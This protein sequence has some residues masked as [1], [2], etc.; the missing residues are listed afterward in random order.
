MFKLQNLIFL[1]ILILL[2]PSI[3]YS[4]FNNDR[5]FTLPVGRVTISPNIR[6]YP[7]TVNEYEVDAK[8]MGGN[9]NKIFAAWKSYGPSY[10]GTGFSLSADGGNSWSGNYQMF[11]PNSGDPG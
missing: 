1:C 6:P 8:T 4:Q 2:F 7:S 10:N 3:Q 11:M 5:I 9:T